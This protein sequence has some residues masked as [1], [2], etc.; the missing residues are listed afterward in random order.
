[1]PYSF[2]LHVITLKSTGCSHDLLFVR[3][4]IYDMKKIHGLLELSPRE[5]FDTTIVG[6]SGFTCARYHD[7]TLVVPG[8]S[9]ALKLRCLR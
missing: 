2:L 8:Q 9:N 1:M 5:F 6:R 7:L 4:V 3:Y